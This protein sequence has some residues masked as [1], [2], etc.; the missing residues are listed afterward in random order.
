MSTGALSEK[1]F[2]SLLKSHKS[3]HQSQ[4][5]KIQAKSDAELEFLET[6]REYVLVLLLD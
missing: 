1:E 4:A 3:Q 6:I 2:K 5:A